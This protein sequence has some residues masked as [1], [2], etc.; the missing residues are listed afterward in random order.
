MNILEN[1]GKYID[2]PGQYEMIISE[3]TQG[4][5]KN[6]EEYV[7]VVYTAENDKTFKTNYTN[8][9]SWGFKL[10][11]LCRSC[12]LTDS[13]LMNF[14]PNMIVNKRVRVTLTINPKDGKLAA[15]DAMPTSYSAAM[16]E[17]P[18]PSP[19]TKDDVPF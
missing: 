5:D 17:L 4:Y 6:G 7:T 9:K 15:W 14:S 18:A 11:K 1:E 19:A 8:N 2:Q 10:A 3:A 16:P 12:G 13:Q